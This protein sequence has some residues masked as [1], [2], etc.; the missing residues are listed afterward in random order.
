LSELA[1][2]TA[3][4]REDILPGYKLWPA[5]LLD[6]AVVEEHLARQHLTLAASASVGL[7]DD[8]ASLLIHAA[9]DDVAA[10]RFKYGR[11]AF[12]AHVNPK[13]MTPFLLHVLLRREHARITRDQAAALITPDNEA[14]VRRGVLELFGYA[15]GPANQ[16]QE[17]KAEAET[18]TGPQS[19][20]P[21]ESAGSPGP[22]SAT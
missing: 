3:A 17:K 8:V 5:G 14:D 9:T 6:Y 12:D 1:K 21:A 7:P 16:A 10:G 15:F 20:P 11:A 2:L 18:G 13:S 19:S 4:P 22:T